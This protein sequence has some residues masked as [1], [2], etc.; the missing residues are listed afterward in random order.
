MRSTLLSGMERGPAWAPF[1]AARRLLVLVLA[2]PLLA[3]CISEER[4]Q[5]IGDQ[6]ARELNPQLPLVRD[7][8]INQ[9]VTVLGERLAHE[10][11]RPHIDYR[12]YVV[13][14]PEENAFALPGGHIYVTTG[15]LQRT[16]TVSE[17]A[18]VLAHEIAHVAARHGAQKLERHLRTGTLMSMMYHIILGGEPELLDHQ[19]LHLGRRIWS[20]QHSRSDEREADALAVRYMAGAGID[21]NGL[22]RLLQGLK[23]EEE[24]YPER[25]FAWFATHPM[26]A[27][28]V[29]WVR[30][31][32]DRLPEHEATARVPETP[33]FSAFRERV[34]A[35]L[36]LDYIR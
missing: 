8:A 36:V 17:L 10:S 18:A 24:A 31:E 26:T 16:E 25:R 14:T 19:A 20:A 7:P 11:E 3:G 12:F 4:E 29:R 34:D 27:D 23:A 6:I 33:S 1:L 32:I 5:A 9:L 15:I 30:K 21:P 22:L 2:A 28:R 13:N 35:A